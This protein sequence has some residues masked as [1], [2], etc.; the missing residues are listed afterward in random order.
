MRGEC[1]FTAEF[2]ALRLGIGP[3]PRRALGYTPAFELRRDA[4]HGKDKLGKIG[5]GIDNRLGNRTQAR[6]GAPR[7]AGNHHKIGR[8]A[9]EAVNGR[10][11]DNIAG[12]EGGLTAS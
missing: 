11:N 9:R 12:R 6:A 7:V 4:K 8:I 10:G 3:A 1:R 5:R 2:D